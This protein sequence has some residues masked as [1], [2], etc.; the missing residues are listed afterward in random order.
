MDL[1]NINPSEKE[2]ENIIIDDKSNKT[3]PQIISIDVGIKNLAYCILECNLEKKTYSII[4]W[5]I[6][7]LCEND[8]LCNQIMAN[9]NNNQKK[10]K[11]KK[12]KVISGKNM[13]LLT[14]IYNNN[15]NNNENNISCKPLNNDTPE[16]I[17]MPT[18]YCNNKA[19]FYKDKDN[20]CIAH[21]KTSNYI[22]P[23]SNDKNTKISTIKKNKIDDLKKLI[24]KYN[25][26]LDN[27]ITYNR[28]MLLDKV[29]TYMNPMI[30]N[31]I[32]NNNSANDMD[33]VSMGISLRR[34]LNKLMSV[35]NITDIIIENQIS[36]IAN[37]MKT[38]QG[39]IAQYFIMNDKKSIVFA[40]SIN[41]LKPFILPGK[42]TE[43]KDRKK[44]GVNITRGILELNIDKH[45]PKDDNLSFKTWLNIFTI[46]KKKDDLADSFLQGLWFIEKQYLIK[47]EYVFS[48]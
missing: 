18:V 12:T 6:I 28:D 41:K 22:I 8:A 3:H 43:Y 47:N 24:Q 4:H 9:K 46:H 30:L 38:L 27:D 40:S 31:K 35:S 1:I 5:G 48:G 37:R 26:T 33:L 14:N 16:I 34:E 29:L 19:K 2:K 32:E 17:V 23:S 39:M 11:E 42:K 15:E 44:M 45:Q 10:T 7:N 20:F 25:I 21:A 13:Q 36:P